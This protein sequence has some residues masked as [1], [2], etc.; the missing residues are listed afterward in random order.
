[1]SIQKGARGSYTAG[2]DLAIYRSVKLSSGSGTGVAYADAADESIGITMNSA[3]SGEQAVV[4]H[5]SDTGTFKLTMAG[6]VS[7][8]DTLYPAAD[9]KWDDALS[10]GTG[11]FEAL[12]AS[13]ADGDIIECLPLS[14]VNAKAG[15]LLYSNPASSTSHENTTDAAN[16]DTFA[17]IDGTKLQVGDVI[18]IRGQVFVE[19]QNGSDTLTLLLKFGTETLLTSGAVAVSD[20]DIWDFHTFVTIRTLGG[21]GTAKAVSHYT[22]LDATATAVLANYLVAFTEDISGDVVIA[23]NAD[24]SAAH[25][26]NEAQLDSFVVIHHRR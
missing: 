16:F 13:A 15:K 12:E 7:I 11:A 17:T 9:G 21:S 26:D 25:G 1:M 19:D 8:G 4:R 3:L 18:E 14:S 10:A 23:V 20:N 24:W 5:L 22:A 2:E 6:A